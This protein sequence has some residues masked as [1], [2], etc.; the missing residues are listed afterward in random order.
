MCQSLFPKYGLATAMDLTCLFNMDTNN[1][2]MWFKTLIIPYPY[3]EGYWGFFNFPCCGVEWCLISLAHLYPLC[4]RLIERN[5]GGIVA[6]TTDM[7]GRKGV[8]AAYKKLILFS[9]T[10]KSYVKLCIVHI[11]CILWIWP[12]LL[13]DAI[14]LYNY[15]WLLEPGTLPNSEMPHDKIC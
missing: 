15:A 6:C 5:N 13:L 1:V 8:N 4:C 3:C 12:R 11:F 10:C 14:Y 9:C 2:M 7:W